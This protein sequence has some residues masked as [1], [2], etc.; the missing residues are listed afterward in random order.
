MQ[1]GDWGNS[2]SNGGVW[3]FSLKKINIMLYRV[4]IFKRPEGLKDSDL[5]SA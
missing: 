4:V 5:I 3:E 2:G 1:E